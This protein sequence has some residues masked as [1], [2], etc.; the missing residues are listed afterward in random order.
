MKPRNARKEALKIAVQGWSEIVRGM[1]GSA[2][3]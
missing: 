2:M 3:A 1:S